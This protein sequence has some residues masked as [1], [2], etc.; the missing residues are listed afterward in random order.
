MSNICFEKTTSEERK[1]IFGDEYAKMNDDEAVKVFISL[2]PTAKITAERLD[3]LATELSARWDRMTP[4]ERASS[5]LSKLSFVRGE[6]NKIDL[7]NA[8]NVNELVDFIK[9]NAH[10]RDVYGKFDSQKIAK[11][12]WTPEDIE[13]KHVY[14]IVKA[15]KYTISAFKRRD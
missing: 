14:T 9:S 3:V 11:K 8:N 1:A 13:K 10:T 4:E 12:I 7:N 2:E 5:P 6:T 15:S